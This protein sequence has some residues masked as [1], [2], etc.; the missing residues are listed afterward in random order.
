MEQGD[1]GLPEVKLE[2]L[3]L[4]AEISQNHMKDKDGNIDIACFDKG[5]ADKIEYTKGY[6]VNSKENSCYRN[7]EE[8]PIGARIQLEKNNIRKIQLFI[9]KSP[10]VLPDME[11]PSLSAALVK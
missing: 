4:L 3:K 6:L 5:L 10:N 2:C 9:S 8:E 1:I 11:H 7:P